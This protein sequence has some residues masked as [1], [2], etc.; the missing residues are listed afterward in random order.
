MLHSI[1]PKDDEPI[2]VT[3]KSPSDE[4]EKALIGEQEYYNEETQAITGVHE[5]RNTPNNESTEQI[6]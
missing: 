5:Q 2:P 4:E 1:H 3:N 6:T